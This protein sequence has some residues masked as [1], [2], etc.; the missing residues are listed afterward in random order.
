[1]IEWFTAR[2]RETTDGCRLDGDESGVLQ[3]A[4]SFYWWG[5][6]HERAQAVNGG[7]EHAAAWFS[8]R[9]TPRTK[10]NEKEMLWCTNFSICVHR[11]ILFFRN[12]V[13]SQLFVFFCWDH[14]LRETQ[15][16]MIICQY[17]RQWK[18]LWSE[19]KLK[20]NKEQT[21]QKS[22]K[23]K[24]LKMQFNKARKQERKKEERKNKAVRWSTE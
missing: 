11:S 16:V 21:S 22:T 9:W 20:E 13:Q 14:V 24:L 3:I 1:M 4:D 5:D 12:A 2:R 15:A 18:S 7:G 23:S 8:L 19:E 17:S 10:K 6:T